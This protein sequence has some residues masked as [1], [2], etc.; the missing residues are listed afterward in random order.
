MK[1]LLV[2]DKIFYHNHLGYAMLRIE[3]K[4]ASVIQPNY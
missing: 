3:N 2:K 1:S 4:G